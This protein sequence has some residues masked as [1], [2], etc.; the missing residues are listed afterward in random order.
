MNRKKLCVNL[1]LFGGV[2]CSV[3]AMENPV[4]EM[5]GIVVTATRAEQAIEKIPNGIAVINKDQIEKSGA[6]DLGELLTGVSGMSLQRKD[7]RKYFSIRGFDARYSLILIDG[8]RLPSEPEK[9]FEAD[10]ILL[11]NVERVEVVK[12]AMSSL[13]GSDALGGVIN[14]ITA[15]HEKPL[16]EIDLSPSWNAN[17]GAYSG[18]YGFT[19]GTGQRNRWNL[20][21]SGET[22][23]TG[24]SLKSDSTTYYPFGY[25]DVLAVSAEYKISDNSLLL[26]ESTYMKERNHEYGMFQSMTGLLETDLYND[27]SREEY[28]ALYRKRSDGDE[29]KI[30]GY[31]SVLKKYNDLKNRNKNNYLNA[32]YGY[33]AIDGLD[34]QHVRHV[35]E[36]N[37]MTF[38]GEIRREVFKGTGITTGRGVFTKTYHDRTYAGS[39]DINSYWGIYFQDEWSVNNKL[40]VVGALRYDDSSELEGNISPK[41]GMNYKVNNKWALKFNAGKSFKAPTPNQRFLKLLVMRNGRMTYLNGN[42]RLK[43]EKSRSWDIGAEYHW[44]NLECSL[45]YFDNHVKDMIDEVWIGPNAKEYQNINKTRLKGVEADIIGKFSNKINWG[46]HYTQ[47]A[48]KNAVSGEKLSDRADKTISGRISYS[49]NDAWDINITVNTMMDM[50]CETGFGERVKKSFTTAD[51]HIN[52]HFGNQ[53]IYFGVQDIGNYKD[54]YLSYSGTQVYVGY[55]AKF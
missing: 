40:F 30:M 10:R 18:K 36:H 4:Y 32:I 49:P 13:Y 46:I 43:S 24:E 55:R 9:D 3:A 52:R 48:A 14:V 45:T 5:D 19:V 39:E 29:W 33:Y 23:K 20:T 54:D 42:D 7:N 8:K 25:R 37:T 51:I 17:S 2:S 27:D 47:L 35:N 21:V 11:Q 28:S 16:V 44:R 26:L 1:S 34:I 38:G 41:F 53:T 50:L 31:R 6:R 22:S 15:K 12:G